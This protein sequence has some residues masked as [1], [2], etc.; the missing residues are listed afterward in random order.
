MLSKT[1][2]VNNKTIIIAI[3]LQHHEWVIASLIL[4]LRT[5]EGKYPGSGILCQIPT[6]FKNYRYVENKE[7]KVRLRMTVEHNILRKYLVDRITYKSVKELLEIIDS[8]DIDE[9]WDK[10][11]PS[12]IAYLPDNNVNENYNSLA[13]ATD[14]NI[15]NLEITT[16][17]SGNEYGINNSEELLKLFVEKG[18]VLTTEEG[19]KTWYLA[20]D[21]ITKFYPEE[22]LNNY[23]KHLET[24]SVQN[25][26]KLKIHDGKQHRY[27]W[28][29]C[30][31]G[32]IKLV[33]EYINKWN[34]VRL[35][36][37]KPLKPK[38]W[39][40][41]NELVRVVLIGSEP[42]WIAEDVCNIL[43]LHTFQAVFGSHYSHKDGKKATTGGVDED[44]RGVVFI[45]NCQ[46][47]LTVDDD[48]L[49]S[50]NHQQ[51]TVINHSQAKLTLPQKSF[52]LDNQQQAAIINHSQE[53][54]IVDDDSL[55]SGHHRRVVVNEAGLYQLIFKTEKPI[56]RKLRRFVTTEILPNIRKH[57]Y[58]QLSSA[59]EPPTQSK[60]VSY[61]EFLKK[62]VA[63]PSTTL[64][65]TRE[66]EFGQHLYADT[67]CSFGKNNNCNYENLYQEFVLDP[68]TLN[69]A[70]ELDIQVIAILEKNYGWS[71]EFLRA[72][73]YFLVRTAVRACL[74][75][76]LLN[77]KNCLLLAQ[78]QDAMLL[79][80]LW[81]AK[82]AN[83]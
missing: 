12:P 55:W 79:Q 51:G 33:S 76:K 25:K 83:G 2:T 53:D 45:D 14:E 37:H 8:V 30:Y 62:K 69:L 18:W 38:L 81:A 39:Q 64:A 19:F 17:S 27:Y 80:S 70:L 63:I 71:K 67:V 16:K 77:E 5:D 3:G 35:L 65:T 43:E 22:N 73:K 68:N 57:G 54:L 44:L 60:I 72:K 47:D 32:A 78:V 29:V 11:K 74:Q 50:A 59:T 34:D 24:V 9:F 28:A 61:E 56:G 40:F 31:N 21:L 49:W 10:P 20:Y 82:Q 7:G 75:A 52:Q 46:E 15:E 6:D 26:K 66:E 1:I 23:N 36:A 4:A 41:E 58:Y 13:T 48:S 42:W